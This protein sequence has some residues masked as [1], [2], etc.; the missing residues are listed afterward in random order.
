MHT[1]DVAGMNNPYG[2]TPVGNKIIQKNAAIL[3]PKPHRPSPQPQEML[4]LSSA[5]DNSVK[6][7][8]MSNDTLRLAEDNEQRI[9][10][11]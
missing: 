8:H 9:R 10:T 2:N 5:I 1:I 11:Y 4:N 7:F 3:S 6:Q